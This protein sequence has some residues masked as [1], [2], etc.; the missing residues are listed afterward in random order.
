MPN[1]RWLATEK[2][3]KKKMI[4]R[5]MSTIRH[6]I[7]FLLKGARKYSLIF[8]MLGWISC[9]SVVPEEPFSPDYYITTVRLSMV[10][11]D[12]LGVPTDIVSDASFS[13]PD[14]LGGYRPQVQPLVVRECKS[15]EGRLFLQDER[16]EV[17]KD[18]S[19]VM[20]DE[21]G[22]FQAFY[23]L[24]GDD[25]AG[26]IIIINVLD[27]DENR[28]PL[29]LRFLADVKSIA[30]AAFRLHIV[31]RYYPANHKDGMAESGYSLV[32]VNIP[33]SIIASPYACDE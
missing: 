12:E 13:D 19:D 6:H 17:P 4:N 7:F 16:P 15:Y 29:G 32:N 20:Q 11:L 28:V 26:K 21:A 10:E 25:D 9:D 27:S 30:T 14:G 3:W 5:H 2:S 1:R 22:Q 18:I 33:V 8:L 24:E 23:T 31:V